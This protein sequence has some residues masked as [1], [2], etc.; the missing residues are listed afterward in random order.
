MI[1]NVTFRSIL[2][3]LKGRCYGNQLSFGAN[4]RKIGISHLH[5]MRRRSTVNSNIA[6]PMFAIAAVMTLLRCVEI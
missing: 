6:K 5:L 2:R 3:S 1:Y 4:K